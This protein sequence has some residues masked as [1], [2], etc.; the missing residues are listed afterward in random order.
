V[1]FVSVQAE[2]D[3]QLTTS[4]V[5]CEIGTLWSVWALLRACSPIWLSAVPRE[6]RVVMWTSTAETERGSGVRGERKGLL[7]NVHGVRSSA[8]Q[9]KGFRYLGQRGIRESYEPK[10]LVN[11][12][13]FLQ[14]ARTH[15][16]W[17]ERVEVLTP[18]LGQREHAA[19]SV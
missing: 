9:G 14:P 8:A 1:F 5:A 13:N 12:I 17:W 11:L 16:A 15:A 10:F 3:E 19:G 18:R 6:L 4:E 7:W 2:E